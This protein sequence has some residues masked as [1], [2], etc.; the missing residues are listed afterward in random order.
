MA[1]RSILKRLEPLGALSADS[2]R[3]ISRMCYVE[4]VSRNLDP[5]RLKGLAGPGR[6]P[7]QGRAEAGSARLE[8]GNPGRRHG[9]LLRSLDKRK[10]PSS[11]TKAI[12][13]VELIR[14]DE[15]VLDIMLTWDQLAAPTAQV[16]SKSMGCHR[17]DGLAHA[18]RH[19][20]R[21]EPDQ[22]HF[23][24]PAA[25]PHRRT[26]VHALPAH[27]GAAAGDHPRGRRRATSTT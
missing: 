24:Q 8:F 17:H 19:V 2:L 10:P 7:R 12:T 11:A 18:I 25:G 16:A 9:S 3:E 15:E 13:D 14:I 27:Q 20:C 4:K 26:A 6:L 23:F 22:R 5:F 21:R 1:Y